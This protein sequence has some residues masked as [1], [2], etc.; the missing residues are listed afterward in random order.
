MSISIHCPHCN[1]KTAL[2]VSTNSHG[3]A[4]VWKNQYGYQ[5]WIGICNGCGEPC[6]V[7]ENGDSIAF[8]IYI[9]SM[10]GKLGA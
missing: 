3:Q 6:L 4:N 9:G 1:Q 2:S 10:C 8:N 5:W 7:R